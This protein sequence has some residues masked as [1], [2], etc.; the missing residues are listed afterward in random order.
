MMELIATR[1]ADGVPIWDFKL[2]ELDAGCLTIFPDEGPIATVK[3][4]G[5]EA[6]VTGA[7]FKDCLAAADDAIAD[8][9]AQSHEGYN[10]D[11]DN[12]ISYMRHLENKAMDLAARDASWGYGE[13]Y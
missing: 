4:D 2:G 1:V 11:E 6:T 5:L 12:E 8:L 7:N 13:Y 10:E 3:F 9:E